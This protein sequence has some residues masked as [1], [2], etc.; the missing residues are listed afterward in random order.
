MRRSFLRRGTQ[1]IREFEL[2]ILIAFPPDRGETRKDGVLGHLTAFCKN[3]REKGSEGGKSKLSKAVSLSGG[4][5][6]S[7]EERSSL[8]EC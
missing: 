4:F 6:Y 2:S 8:K 5:F 3:K 1:G 7:R